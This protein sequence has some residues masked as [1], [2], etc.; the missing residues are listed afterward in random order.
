MRLPR[1]QYR[2]YINSPEWATL[3]KRFFASRLW[4]NSYHCACACCWRRVPVDLHHKTYTRLGFEHLQDLIPI[5]R[6]CHV[7]T[8]EVYREGKATGL[9]LR[10]AHKIIKGRMRVVRMEQKQKY[11]VGSKNSR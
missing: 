4:R 8:H 10:N 3:R 6:E 5:C 9:W 11:P 7:L 2:D 1:Y